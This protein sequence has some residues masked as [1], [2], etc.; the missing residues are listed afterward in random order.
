MWKPVDCPPEARWSVFRSFPDV[1][2]PKYLFS[3]LATLFLA[4]AAITGT[5]AAD[6]SAGRALTDQ[7]G[8]EDSRVPAI[9]VAPNNGAALIAWRNRE[10]NSV[11]YASRP[12][13]GSFSGRKTLEGASGS[14]AADRPAVALSS[15]GAA[16]AAWT[17]ASS[18]EEVVMASYRPSG[19]S[20]S[21]PVVISAAGDDGT[22]PDVA[23]DSTGRAVVVWSIA[24]GPSGQRFAEASFHGPSGTF[25]AGDVLNGPEDTGYTSPLQ[26]HVAMDSTGNA[27]AVFPSQRPFVLGDVNPV[28]WA[29]MP[30]ESTS[31]NAPQDLGEGA[32]PDIAFGANDRATVVWQ[33]DGVIR[34]SEETASSGGGFAAY[35]RVSAVLDGSASRPDVGVDGAGNATVVYQVDHVVKVATRPPGSDFGTPQTISSPG[36]SGDAQVA[37]D[38]AGNAAT[39]WARFDGV[40]ETVEGSYRPAGSGFST[41]K[42]LTA[43]NSPGNAPTI[44]IDGSGVATAAWETADPFGIVWT[45]TFTQGTTPPPSGEEGG[46]KE[47]GGGQTGGGTGSSPGGSSAPQSTPSASTPNS[48]V[49]PTSRPV[50]APKCRKGFKKKTVAGKPK[51]VKAMPKKHGAKH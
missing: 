34:A 51:C 26:A 38:P 8:S 48:N 14:T 22:A 39:V 29:Y 27:I 18:G 36:D 12:A 49:P 37:V 35:K 15:A 11:L 21:S 25:G 42:T 9:A 33:R 17:R 2:H 46:P 20:F 44:A 50:A 43:A 28:Q 32:T 1:A 23:I 24:S 5:A 40:R 6:W 10:S 19:G 7:L 31:F 47:E 45:S 4:F 41:A 30:S 13:G 3:L 16:V